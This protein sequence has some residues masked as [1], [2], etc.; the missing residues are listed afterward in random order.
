MESNVAVVLLNSILLTIRCSQYKEAAVT[1]TLL[2]PSAL[3]NGG[4]QGRKARIQKATINHPPNLLHTVE[5]E[6]QL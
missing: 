2:E 3:G 1:Q 5:A 4:G 6:G